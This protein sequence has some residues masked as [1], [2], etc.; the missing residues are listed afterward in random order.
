MKINPGDL[1]HKII[2]QKHTHSIDDV[3]NSVYDWTNFKT[4]YAQINNLY[5]DEYWKAAAH[6]QENMVVFIIRWTAELDKLINNKMLTE[7]R[8]LYKDIPYEIISFDNIKYQ[9][10]LVKIK[11][12]NK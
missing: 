3:G 1:R 7:Y 8:I 9:N 11:A 10:K 5:G 2:I 12:V 4:I 6:N